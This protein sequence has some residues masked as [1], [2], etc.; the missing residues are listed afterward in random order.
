VRRCVDSVL[1]MV[2]L[3]IRAHRNAARIV[4]VTYCHYIEATLFGLLLLKV[5][6]Y[7][8]HDQERMVF[9]W[10][11][12]EGNPK[13]DQG[14]NL[15]MWAEMLRW[16]PASLLTDPRV[17]WEP[18]DDETALLVVPFKV[19]QARFVVRFDP[20]SGQIR[21]NDV[22]FAVLAALTDVGMPIPQA[23]AVIGCDD[24]PL[25]AIRAGESAEE[26]PPMAL[27]IVARA[28]A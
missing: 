8:V 4:R 6:E 9:P 14:G 10:G 19:G 25:L 18:V 26:M 2:D 1:L 11:V 27:S 28:S 17:R 16:L 12:Q 24:I 7:Y 20:T 22:A 23:V 15:G 5:N 21:Y 13:L 3:T